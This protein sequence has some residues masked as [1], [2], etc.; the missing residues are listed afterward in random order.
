LGLAGITYIV[1]LSLSIITLLIIVFFSYRQTIAAYPG[2]GGSYTVARRNL[3][4]LPG[5]LAVAPELIQLK[6]P[7]RFVVSSIVD[8]VIELSEANRDRRVI[9]TVPE[10]V[11]KEWFAYFLHT[12]RAMLLRPMRLMKGNDRISVL[13]TPW[14]LK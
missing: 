13:N 5:L 6:T 14:Y 2:G 7:F 8:Y 11:E 3:G 4:T 12:Q 9:T 10:L 1:P